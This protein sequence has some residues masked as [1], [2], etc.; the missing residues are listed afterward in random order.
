MDH[1]GNN[2]NGQTSADYMQVVNNG[3]GYTCGVCKLFV[4]YGT[5]HI[6]PSQSQ[7]YS[8]PLK[9]IDEQI[10]DELRAIRKLLEERK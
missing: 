8:V 6:C 2:T 3:G 9:R 5:L 1:T 4:L 7:G 10:L